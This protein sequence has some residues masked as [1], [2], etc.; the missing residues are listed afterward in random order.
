MKKLNLKNID[1]IKKLKT[2]ENVLLS[3]VV[4]T[5][6][7][8]TLKKINTSKKLTFDLNN[9]FLFFCGPSPT[10]KGKTSGSLGPTTSSR[11]SEYFEDIF[12]KGVVGLLGKGQIDKK[13]LPLFKKYGTIL[14]SITGGVAALLAQKIKKA[15]LI[16]F[17]ELGPEA[18]Y[19]LE[20]EDFPALV[21]VDTKGNTIFK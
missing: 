15:Q 3:G 1:E 14:F 17:K 8:S 7:D 19:E 16:A 20:I 9:N 18:V 2:G 4:F 10:P 11:M 21:A 12:K 13:Y 6:R 5:V